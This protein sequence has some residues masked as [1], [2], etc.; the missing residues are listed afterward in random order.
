MLRT[1]IEFD[2]GVV[3]LKQDRAQAKE[4]GDRARLRNQFFHSLL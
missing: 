2:H 1:G 3:L 4:A